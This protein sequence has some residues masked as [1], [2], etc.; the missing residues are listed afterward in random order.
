MKADR[1][2]KQKSHDL[3]C[4][5]CAE[6]GRD[7]KGHDQGAFAET[8]ILCLGFLSIREAGYTIYS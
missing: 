4:G 8:W 7:L 2:S 3:T 1:I 6:M 5:T